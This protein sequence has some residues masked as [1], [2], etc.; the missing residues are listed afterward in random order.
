MWQGGGCEGV[1]LREEWKCLALGSWSEVGEGEERRYRLEEAGQ[2]KK[3][4]GAGRQSFVIVKV[5]VVVVAAALVVAAQHMVGRSRN[6]THGC[7]HVQLYC[8]SCGLEDHS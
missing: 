3:G 2:H 7:Y 1:A 5:V 8:G 4:V 6:Q